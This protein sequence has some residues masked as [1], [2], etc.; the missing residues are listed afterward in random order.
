MN[1][2]DLHQLLKSNPGDVENAVDDSPDSISKK[3]FV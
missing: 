3:S 1:Y 2:Q